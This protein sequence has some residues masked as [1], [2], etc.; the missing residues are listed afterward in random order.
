MDP[1]IELL[2]L[3]TAMEDMGLYPA[4]IVEEDKIKKRT[5]WQDGWNAHRTELLEKHIALEK[6]YSELPWEVLEHL[7]PLLINEDIYL[8]SWSKE[9][10]FK[11][12]ILCNDIFAWGCSDTEE[13]EFDELPIIAQ[14]VR[15]DKFW[16][17]IKYVC[18]KR[19][20]KP[21]KPVIKNMKTAGVWDQL[22]EDLPDNYYDTQCLNKKQ[23]I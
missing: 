3:K 21:Q 17:V 4:S 19:R 13:V 20:E 5:E 15:E 6:W 12:F 9:N 16:G 11:V 2:L 22:L 23:E 1:Q 10:E 8:S 14:F 7:E 18:H